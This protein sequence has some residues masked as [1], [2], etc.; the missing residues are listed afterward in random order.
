M[1]YFVFFLFEILG[2][3]GGYAGD[4]V[5]YVRQMYGVEAETNCLMDFRFGQVVLRQW[6]KDSILLEASF[7]VTNAEEWEK[8]ELARH[9]GFRLDSWP[10]VWKLYLEIAAGFNREADLKAEI[11]VWVPQRITLDL[12]N[13]FGNIYLPE[14]HAQLPLSLTAVY[15]NIRTDSIASLPETELFFNVSY[16]KLEI[17]RCGK[18]NVRS[19]YSSV[20]VKSARYLQI[21]AEK[22]YIAL[23]NTDTIVSQG[24]YNN[25]DIR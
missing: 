14:Y 9:L 22:S 17:R 11:N 15:G 6:E 1:K 3:C 10:G 16:G 19:A 2:I 20:G 24:E 18:A 8:E 4:Y 7:R 21:K 5:K 25:Y 23:S 12:M 13:R